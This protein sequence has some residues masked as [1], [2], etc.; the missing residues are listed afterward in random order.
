MG[1]H[2]TSRKGDSLRATH[3]QSF[4]TQ[5]HFSHLQR[6]NFEQIARQGATRAVLIFHLEHLLKEN[7]LELMVK[8]YRNVEA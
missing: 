5:A 8:N 1:D 4:Q 6:K 3:Q 7:T 2:A